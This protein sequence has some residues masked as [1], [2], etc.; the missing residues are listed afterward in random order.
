MI[1]VK[2][3]TVSIVQGPKS[4]PRKK[5]SGHDDTPPRWHAKLVA[6]QGSVAVFEKLYLITEMLPT[7]FYNYNTLFLLYEWKKNRA[8]TDNAK[9]TDR[10]TNISFSAVKFF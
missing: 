7:W 9:N 1:S 6:S 2:R 10:P 3:W 8:S 4:P 5:T